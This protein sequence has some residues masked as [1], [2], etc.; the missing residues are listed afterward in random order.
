M[1]T[2]D[3]LCLFWLRLWSRRPSLWIHTGTVVTPTD[4]C[5]EIHGISHSTGRFLV[6]SSRRGTSTRIVRQI[7]KTNDLN[8][9]TR[10][11]K[12]VQAP[13]PRTVLSTGSTNEKSYTF[14]CLILPQSGIAQ[15]ERVVGSFVDAPCAAEDYCLACLTDI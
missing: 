2:R 6:F 13:L 14:R 4:T 9:D 12:G 1:V 11:R 5:L 8:V 7:R 15:E 3:S 10:E